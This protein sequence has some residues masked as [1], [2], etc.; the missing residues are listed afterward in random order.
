MAKKPAKPTGKPAAK[1]PKPAANSPTWRAELR[2]E[3]A[4][5]PD[6]FAAYCAARGADAG[7]EHA[8]SDHLK[9][10]EAWGTELAERDR[11]RGVAALVGIAQ[12][13]FP[14]AM[15]S[16]GSKADNMGFHASEA[17]MDGAPV[18]AQIQRGA[19]WLVDP[20]E[21]NLE[22][23]IAGLDP[24][25]Q[26]NVWDEDLLPQSDEDAWFWYSEVGQ[27]IAHAIS[28]EGG[29]PKG[30]SY[31]EWTPSLSVGRGMVMAVRGLRKGGDDASVISEL[32][33]GMVG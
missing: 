25:R 20:S 7:W 16:A 29:D 24:S 2:E 32:R 27:C 33:T 17:S 21:E 6:D 26:L 28:G 9:G 30:A 5:L 19:A 22:L 11:R 3:L 23:V 13:G 15:A 8:D 4:K 10:L 1:S 18:E 12:V 31:Y 14:R